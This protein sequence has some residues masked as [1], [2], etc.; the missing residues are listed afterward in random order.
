MAD[1]RV[2]GPAAPKPA[3][4]RVVAVVLVGADERVLRFPVSPPKTLEVPASGK[5]PLRIELIGD[6]AYL[7][8][9]G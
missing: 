3:P 5:I 4:L 1:L 9:E 2:Q 7:T 8:V 6:R